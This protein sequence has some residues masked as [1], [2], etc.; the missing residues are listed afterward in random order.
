LRPGG[1]TGNEF[2]TPADNEAV[3]PLEE[4][5]ST[6]LETGISIVMEPVAG[7]G[8]IGAEF[9]FGACDVCWA[10]KKEKLTHPRRITNNEAR[11]TARIIFFFC[12]LIISP[13]VHRISKA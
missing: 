6:V 12:S 2:G 3:K 5:S 13:R 10:G 11:T 1:I 4:L 9:D 7:P 8:T